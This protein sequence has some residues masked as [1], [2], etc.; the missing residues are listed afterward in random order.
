MKYDGKASEVIGKNVR[1]Y[2]LTPRG[3]VIIQSE[4]GVWF[5]NDLF[6]MKLSQSVEELVAAS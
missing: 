2:I 5:R 4:D 3:S 1:D 6:S